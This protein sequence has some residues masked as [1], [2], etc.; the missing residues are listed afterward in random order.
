[1]NLSV[2]FINDI[3]DVYHTFAKIVAELPESYDQ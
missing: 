2:S 1:M 3:L